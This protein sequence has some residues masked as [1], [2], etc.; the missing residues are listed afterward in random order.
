MLVMRTAGSSALLCER[1]GYD[2]GGLGGEARG[3]ACPE[4]GLAVS[5]SLPT[6]RTG[7]AWQRD[8]GPLGWFLVNG[9]VLLHP[10]G[11]WRIVQ[12]A[13]GN[14]IGLAWQNALAAGMLAGA[15][16]MIPGAGA[17][18][19]ADIVYAVVF[20]LVM[21]LVILLLTGVEYVGI[22]FFGRRRGWR[23]TRGVAAAVCGHASVGWLASG[24]GVGVGWHAGLAI[25][26]GV[27]AVLIG[28]VSWS[29]LLPIVG[30]M[31]GLVAFEVLVYAGFTRMRFAN[32][33]A[34]GGQ[35]GSSTGG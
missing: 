12:P 23:V 35:S 33:P 31:A 34:A 24:V 29:M 6:K 2:L 17:Q 16:M 11:V 20:A 30:F 22:R 15:A 14:S 8:P 28:R 21:A 5:E 26:G 10:L 19:P 4:C 18:P 25:G 3:G 1:C 32:D 13:V 27:P 9:S 7:T